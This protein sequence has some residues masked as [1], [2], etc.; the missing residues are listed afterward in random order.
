VKQEQNRHFTALGVPGTLFDLDKMDS[1]YMSVL[2]TLTATLVTFIVGNI[3]T[4]YLRRPGSFAVPMVGAD[5][6]DINVLKG[7]YVQEA[8]VL[9][10]EGHKKV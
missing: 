4:T 1:P 8:D 2:F 3:I 10:R 5:T 7:R 6:G 9:L